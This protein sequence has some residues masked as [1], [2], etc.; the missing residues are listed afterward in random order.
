M[1]FKAFVVWDMLNEVVG[2]F[3]W[4]SFPHCAL[5]GQMN[6]LI[7][8]QVSLLTASL[9]PGSSPFSLIVSS[10]WAS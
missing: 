8:C 9:S 10:K 7:S 2:F 5:W 3:V 4:S 6:H 1:L